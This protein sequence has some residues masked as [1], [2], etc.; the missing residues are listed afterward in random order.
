MAIG[1]S[2]KKKMILGFSGIFLLFIVFGYYTTNQINQL[3]NTTEKMYQHPLTVTRA[4]LIADVN[5]VKMHRSMKDVAL[6]KDSLTLESAIKKVSQYEK[7]VFRQFKIVHERIL[8]ETG[9]ALITKTEQKFIN[10][11]PIR[12]EVIRLMQQSKRQEA[13]DITKQK[14]T[15]HV[16]Q[17]DK[18]M[19]ELVDYA[20]EKGTGFFNKAQNTGAT[21]LYTTIAFMIFFA[22]ITI[23]T[24]ILLIANIT[25]PLARM[26][27]AVNEL[28][29]GN[30][31]MTRRLPVNGRDEIAQVA[32]G[33]NHFIEK[34]QQALIQVKTTAETISSA[35]NQLTSAAQTLSSGSSEQAANIE[36]TSSALEQMGASVSQNSENAKM[37]D[38][39]AVQAA[40]EADDGGQAV[41]NTLNAM[42]E[43]ASKINI[44]E[45]IAYK[46]NLLALNAAIEAARAGEHGKGFAV[47]AAEVRKLAERSQMAAQEIG[48]QATSSV[49]IAEKAGILLSQ[50]VPNIQ[51]TAGLVQEITAASEEQSGGIREVTAAVNQLDRVGQK[52]AAASEQLASTAEQ[53]HA[54]AKSLTNTLSSFNLGQIKPIQ[55][56]KEIQPIRQMTMTKQEVNNTYIPEEPRKASKRYDSPVSL[57]KEFT[58]F[59]EFDEQEF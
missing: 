36:Q 34:V 56:I 51:K 23:I 52:N 59:T 41:S 49:E 28:N 27:K 5:I 8:G 16:E 10:W 35:S 37:T 3:T 26:I 19:D 29:T 17:L 32:D 33:L 15:R 53:M 6:S 9:K 44:I 31:D 39:I 18:L 47:V 2:V 21:A 24:A 12:N 48:I 43:I 55:K 14:G 58:D 4:S 30:G 40:S 1:F 20:A 45:D 7:E 46:T 57:T 42:R 22:I 25:R 11:K 50:M 38:A 54:Q 13:S